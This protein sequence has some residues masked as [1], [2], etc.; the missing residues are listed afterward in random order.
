VVFLFS[1]SVFRWSLL[2]RFPEE[3]LSNTTISSP[4][5]VVPLQLQLVHDTGT[6]PPST[7]FCSKV[8]EGVP[9]SLGDGETPTV[10]E[11]VTDDVVGS[12]FPQLKAWA[13]EPGAEATARSAELSL[14]GIARSKLNKYASSCFP[15]G[16]NASGGGSKIEERDTGKDRAGGT[17]EGIDK[18]S[19]GW[20][21]G[22]FK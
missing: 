16:R 13:D 12:T 11:G 6:T 20:W 9:S 19:S 14:P 15:R 10:G 18:V 7:K 17:S 8:G 3:G 1:I 4:S 5:S 2:T 22:S 21:A